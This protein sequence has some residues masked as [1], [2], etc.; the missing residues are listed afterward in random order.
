MA[1][2]SIIINTSGTILASTLLN[3]QV[4]YLIQLSYL[5]DNFRENIFLSNCLIS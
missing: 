2:L 5:N 3:N 4:I 1:N